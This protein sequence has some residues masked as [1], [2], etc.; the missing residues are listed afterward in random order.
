MQT[1]DKPLELN[2]DEFTD[3]SKFPSTV[4]MLFYADGRI[5][6]YFFKRENLHGLVCFSKE[7]TAI[8][9]SENILD[10]GA[11]P[12]EM[13]FEEAVNTLLERRKT[14]T[15]LQCLFLMD[16]GMHAPTATYWV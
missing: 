11:V 6:G 4:W 1:I 15:Q 2:L 8:I 5:G 12:K 7:N 10:T 14:A 9:F 3:R 16:N 13:P